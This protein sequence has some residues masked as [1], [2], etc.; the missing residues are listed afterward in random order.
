LLVDKTNV[1]WA[2]PIA[3][4]PNKYGLGLFGRKTNAET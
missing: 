2:F 4:K 1:P 3:D